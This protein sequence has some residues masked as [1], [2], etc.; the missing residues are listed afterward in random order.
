MQ[1]RG[2]R[3]QQSPAP[4]LHPSPPPPPSPPTQTLL[5]QL[6]AGGNPFPQNLTA[7]QLLCLPHVSTLHSLAASPLLALPPTLTP[8]AGA[9]T[10]PERAA[11]AAPACATSPTSHRRGRAVGEKRAGDAETESPKRQKLEAG[12]LAPHE[13][14]RASG[15][16]PGWGWGARSPAQGGA[17]R[18]TPCVLEDRSWDIV[19]LDLQGGKEPD[20]GQLGDLELREVLGAGPL[21]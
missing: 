11:G 3:A 2:H 20:E 6:P 19:F 16:P 21:P 10:L 12:L 17:G 18:I 15:P 1:A 5:P 14:P 8:S 13:G 7:A 9:E 4:A